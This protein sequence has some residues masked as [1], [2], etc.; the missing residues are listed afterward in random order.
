MDD[1]QE[2]NNFIRQDKFNNSINKLFEYQ[3]IL[4]LGN[5]I[6]HILLKY[7]TNVFRIENGTVI[8]KLFQH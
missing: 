4:I 5:K 8:Y 2:Q 3:Q 7:M 1:I 6:L